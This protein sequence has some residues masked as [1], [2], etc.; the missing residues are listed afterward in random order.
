MFETIVL[1]GIII[2]YIAWALWTR[3]YGA[4]F[5]PTEPEVVE[6]TMELAQ[7]KEG[8]IFYDLGS[9]DGRLVLAAALRGAQAYGIEI[10]PLRVWY[11]RLWIRMLR[12]GGKAKILK[13]D[14]FTVDYSNATVVN[15]FLLHKTNKALQQ[16]LLKELRP[17]TRVVAYGFGFGDQTPIKIDDNPGSVFGPL[18]LYII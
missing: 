9:G 13:Q 5:V 7:V 2:A 15:L 16:K 4:P 12:L 10:D 6:R 11:S 14:M 8:D 3:K 17:G 18:Y 1:A